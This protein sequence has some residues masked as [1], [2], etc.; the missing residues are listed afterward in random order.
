MKYKFPEITWKNTRNSQFSRKLRQT[1]K[2]QKFI[3]KLRNPPEFIQAMWFLDCVIINTGREK[4]RA[5]YFLAASSIKISAS[6]GIDYRQLSAKCTRNFKWNCDWI[7]RHISLKL[8]CTINYHLW[9]IVLSS[10]ALTSYHLIEMKC[11]TIH[12][13][14]NIIS[15]I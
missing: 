5:Q 10:N 13:W 4:P 15:A 8:I 12:S 2:A 9:Q 3:K 11:E 7:N 14:D 6:L 1:L